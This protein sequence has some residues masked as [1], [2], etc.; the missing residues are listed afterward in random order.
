M[1]LA[2]AANALG[3]S[4]P[5]IKQLVSAKVLPVQHIIGTSYLVRRSDVERERERR[6]EKQLVSA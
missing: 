2:E 3:L 4:R 6:Q 1:T 5:R